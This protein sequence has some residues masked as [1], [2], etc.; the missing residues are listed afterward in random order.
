MIKKYGEPAPEGFTKVRILRGYQNYEI[1]S[2][3]DLPTKD[4]EYLLGRKVVKL[5]VAEFKKEEIVDPEEKALRERLLEESQT[6]VV[7]PSVNRA[8][9]KEGDAKPKRKP[10]RKPGKKKGK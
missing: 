6:R 7:E 10:G 2:I 3:V 9:L 5:F 4:I 8:R 1:G